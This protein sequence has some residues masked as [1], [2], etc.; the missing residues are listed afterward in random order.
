[1][2]R[3]FYKLQTKRDVANVIGVELKVL[4]YILK[5]LKSNY[6]VFSIPKKSGG[7]RTITAPKDDF[8][9]I[10][11]SIAKHLNEHDSYNPKSKKLLSHAYRKDLTIFSNAEKHIKK[12]YVLNFDLENFFPSIHF[13]RIRGLFEKHKDF[14]MEH[15]AADFL[16]RLVCFEWT[17]PQGSPASPVISNLI[18]NILDVRMIRILK[19]HKCTYTRYADDIT[20]SCVQKDFPK[21]IAYINEQGKWSLGI[22][23]LEVLNETGFMLNHSKTRMSY[24][25][26]RQVVT[27]LVV[28]KKVNIPNNYYNRLRVLCN[29]YVQGKD[30]YIDDPEQLNEVERLEGMLNYAYYVRNR[31]NNSSTAKKQKHWWIKKMKNANG[32]HK[33]YQKFLYYKYFIGNSHPFLY[34]EGP[35]DVMHLKN[36]MKKKKIFCSIKDEIADYDFSFWKHRAE[37]NMIL[38]YASG[39][40]G[41]ET[42]LKELEDKYDKYTK[43]EEYKN[44]VILIVDGDPAGEDVF[45]SRKNKKEVEDPISINS[46]GQVE[47]VY[48]GYNVYVLKLPQSLVIENLYEGIT[49]NGDDIIFGDDLPTDGV[50]KKVFATHVRNMN[51]EQLSGFDDV[52]ESIKMI[53]DD[54]SNR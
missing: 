49:V 27:G 25:M 41:M 43:I 9:K 7:E 24:R 42:F 29:W 12:R 8:M 34:T 30:F 45:N 6:K 3:P 22:K 39:T 2:K 52:F 53:L 14:Q 20:I 5:N 23:I 46:S 54:F 16:A 31:E 4:T 38:P 28:N 37:E 48:C 33:L 18:A 26:A 47:T 36:A 10:L 32:I 35:T 40:G 1:M 51:V 17:L 15:E 11:S 50:G 19:G 44:P 21:E 13:G